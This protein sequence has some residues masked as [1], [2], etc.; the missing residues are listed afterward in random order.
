MQIIP[1]AEECSNIIL[2]VYAGASFYN[3]FDKILYDKNRLFIRHP[4]DISTIENLNDLL[5]KIQ[6]HWNKQNSHDLKIYASQNIDLINTL[7]KKPIENYKKFI[8]SL[9]IKGIQNTKISKILHILKPNEFPMLDPVQGKFLIRNYNKNSREHLV[10]AIEAFYKY[11]KN[12]IQ[13][14]KEIEGILVD[15]FG[16]HISCLRVSEL[17]LWIQTQLSL[18]DIKKTLIETCI[19]CRST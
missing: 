13:K 2:G 18:K 10:K 11:H 17:L 16:V 5:T 19:T 6:S 14:I 3:T 15:S 1:T 12:N 7:L 4:I 8:L 9:N